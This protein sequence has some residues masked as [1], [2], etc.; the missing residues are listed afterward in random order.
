MA[1][2]DIQIEVDNITDS[3]FA[4]LLDDILKA[5][6]RAD[7]DGHQHHLIKIDGERHELITPIPVLLKYRRKDLIT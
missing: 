5:C 7:K 1:V 6:C 3:D 2:H 4:E